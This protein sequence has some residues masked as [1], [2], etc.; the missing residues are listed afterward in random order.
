MLCYAREGVFDAVERAFVSAF[1]AQAAHVLK[2][3]SAFE[4]QSNAAELLQRSLLPDTFPVLPGLAVAA[5]Y[6]PAAGSAEVGGDWF[7]CSHCTTGRSSSSSGTS[8]GAGC[9]RGS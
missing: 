8:W 7:A 3:V 4:L 2:R 5:H 6:A 9:P 1:A